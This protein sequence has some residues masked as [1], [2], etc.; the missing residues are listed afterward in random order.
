MVANKKMYY[1]ILTDIV[2]L[3]RYHVRAHHKV[4]GHVMFM[5]ANSDV[6][7]TARQIVELC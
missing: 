4:G 7:A 2:K 1:L 6:S 3:G 5:A